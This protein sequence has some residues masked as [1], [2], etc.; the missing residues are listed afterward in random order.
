MEFGLKAAVVL[1]VPRSVS[2]QQSFKEQRE[3]IRTLNAVKLERTF[4]KPF[5]GA[6]DGHRDGV[7]VLCKHPTSLALLLSGACDGEVGIEAACTALV[8]KVYC[9]NT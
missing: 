8:A 5:L 7:N 6:L 3:Y 1:P 4:A 9:L 2:A